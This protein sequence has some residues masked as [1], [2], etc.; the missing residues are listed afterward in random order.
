MWTGTGPNGRINGRIPLG[1]NSGFGTFGLTSETNHKWIDESLEQKREKL[2]LYGISSV[3]TIA[4]PSPDTAA[5]FFLG[6]II[7]VNRRHWYGRRKRS[8]SHVLTRVRR[9]DVRLRAL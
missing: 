2:R 3:I 5:L 9:R 8:V 4:A 1:S 6:L 7:V